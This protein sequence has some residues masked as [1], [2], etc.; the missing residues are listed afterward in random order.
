[1]TGRPRVEAL[2]NVLDHRVAAEP[3]D[4][5]HLEYVAQRIEGGELMQDIAE[6]L[7]AEAG[8]VLQPS[9]LNAYLTRAFGEPG[10]D[11]IAEARRK[12]AY[13]LG[14]ETVRVIR[15]APNDRDGISRATAESKALGWLA[16]KFNRPVF[17]E[18]PAVS[19]DASRHEHLHLD[20]LRRLSPR[21]EAPSVAGNDSVAVLA[22]PEHG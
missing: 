14:E 2:K 19:I 20:S 7:I 9:T 13:V 11:R 15:N 3:E 8:V 21:G 22:A 12:S 16:S 6:E 4:I 10:Q 18:T 1:M 5:T 17:G